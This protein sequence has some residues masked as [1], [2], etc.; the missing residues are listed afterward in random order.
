MTR[1]PAIHGS[2]EY[3]IL[4]TNIR[5][6]LCYSYRVRSICLQP[7]GAA[8]SPAMLFA[9]TCL[10]YLSTNEPD[11]DTS[12]TPVESVRYKKYKGGRSIWTCRNS[13]RYASGPSIPLESFV[14]FTSDTRWGYLSQKVRS[15]IAV[16]AR[17]VDAEAAAFDGGPDQVLGRGVAGV[18]VEGG[19]ALVKA[20]GVP[21]ITQLQALEIEM[22][23]E[24]VA[25][26]A[27]EG[28]EAGDVFADG[29]THPDADEMSG[30]LVVAEQFRG[31]I[32][33]HAQRACGEDLDPAA[34]DFVKVGGGG[35]EGVTGAADVGAGAFIHGGLDFSGDMREFSV[36]G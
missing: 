31:G 16:G 24:L 26:G 4:L 3:T 8:A 33:A 7:N 27:E 30:G 25:Q 36:G 6:Y 22:M 1:P 10:Q 34:G 28:A 15:G 5:V 11:T 20:A 9:A 18:V 17:P 21:R 12:I 2:F 19:G 29:S 14:Y 35:E 13:R 23:A 32:L